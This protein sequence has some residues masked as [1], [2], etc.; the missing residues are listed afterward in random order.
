MLEEERKLWKMSHPAAHLLRISPHGA[1]LHHRRNSESTGLHHLGEI[2][3]DHI[4]HRV[5]PIL[6]AEHGRKRQVS[7]PRF[8]VGVR[9][10]RHPQSL[11]LREREVTK[12]AK[13][14]MRGDL[15]RYRF[16][17][18]VSPRG[19]RSGVNVKLDIRNREAKMV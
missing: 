5:N 17:M 6:I 11:P 16:G 10:L 3:V 9:I 18:R 2:D 1:Q 12:I 19:A 8:A 14:F 15:R 13:N 7:E 4:P